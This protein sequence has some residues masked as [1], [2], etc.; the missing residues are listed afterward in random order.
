MV[1]KKTNAVRIL[2]GLKIDYELR[3][4]TVDENDLSAETVAAKIGLPLLQVFKTLVVRGDKTGVLMA[5][6][7]GGK[8]LDLKTLAA[9][10][11]NKKA[12]LVP[13]KEVQSLT[14]YI[15]GGVSPVGVK[16][17]YPLF[18][19]ESIRQWPFISISAGVRGCQVLVAPDDLLKAVAGSICNISR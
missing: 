19:D 6:I 18:I 4:Y 7:P 1:L 17:A 8:E 5:C 3:E 13:V 15:R 2:D 16:K 10:S 11:G 14:G 9:V 12:D